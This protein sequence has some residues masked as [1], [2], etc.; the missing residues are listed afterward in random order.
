MDA[1]SDI[2]PKAYLQENVI[3]KYELTGKTNLLLSIISYTVVECST[4]FHGKGLL[5]FPR[6]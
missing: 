2:S 4:F 5:R 3:K 1:K 6:V